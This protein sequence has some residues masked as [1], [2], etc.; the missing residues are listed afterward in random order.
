MNVFKRFK[1]FLVSQDGPT[2]VE[3]GVLLALIVVTAIAAI[4][5]LGRTSKETFEEVARQIETIR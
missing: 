2:S 1:I 3:Y 5:L 4:T